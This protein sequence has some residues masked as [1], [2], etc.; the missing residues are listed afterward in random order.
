[1]AEAEPEPAPAPAP[2][3]PP[4]APEEPEEQPEKQK[5]A[6]VTKIA[7]TDLLDID[8]AAAGFEQA[9]KAWIERAIE[10]GALREMERL[11]L[12]ADDMLLLSDPRAVAFLADKNRDYWRHTIVDTTINDITKAV[13]D[14]MVEGEGYYGIAKRIEGV[15]GE[16]S[17][18]R[19]I[20][21]ARTETVGAY[22]AG[23]LA[24]DEKGG[25]THKEWISVLDDST[26]EDHAYADG[27]GADGS[28]EINDTF[29]VGGDSLRYPGD[30]GGSTEQ[31]VNCRCSMAGFVR[32]KGIS[33]EHK[34]FIIEHVKREQV[35]LERG[36]ARALKREFARELAEVLE[37]LRGIVAE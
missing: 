28:V 30:P 3:P 21:I 35:L 22:N 7:A 17:R 37:K 19:S 6:P 16:A 18:V 33:A 11:G 32:A 15:F 4:E 31:I 1:M 12:S 13:Q 34:A 10:T 5:A 25:A 27:Q 36:M 14:G 23:A 8:R 9:S 24:Q 29:T 20:R 26:R 2:P